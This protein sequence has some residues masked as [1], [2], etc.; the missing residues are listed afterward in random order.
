MPTAESSSNNGGPTVLL[1]L[2]TMAD[3]GSP[4]TD[5]RVP[6]RLGPT[7][8]GRRLTTSTSMPPTA[9]PRCPAT[10]RHTTSTSRRHGP[11]ASSFLFAHGLCTMAICAHHVLGIVGV[12][13]PGRVSRVAVRFASPTPLGAD[14]AVDAYGID[15]GRSHSRR[16]AQMNDHQPR[17]I[18]VA[19][20]T[21]LDIG[22][23]VPQMAF[24]YE[25][26][27]HRAQR[28]EELGIGSVWL[29]DHLYGPGAGPDLL[30]GGVDVGHR[31]AGPH[32][33]T[34]GRTHGV[35]QPVSPP[36]RAGQDGDHS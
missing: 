25:D 31:I 34:A 12:D 17:Q 7:A 1:G 11:A 35:V 8:L 2:H 27:L 18:G 21:G 10:G 14:L 19:A 9:M 20:M 29:Y 23:Y 3:L 28:C 32:R 15:D 26:I 33:A 36:C 4:P 5:H 30:A 16:A 13:D 22:V 24:S 6:N